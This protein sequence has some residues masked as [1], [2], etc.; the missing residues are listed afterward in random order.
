MRDDNEKI[1]EL[2]QYEDKTNILLAFQLCVGR[3]GRYS[4]EI[5]KELREHVFLCLDHGLETRHFYALA[6]LDLSYMELESMSGSIGKLKQLKILE[7]MCNELTDLPPQ[8]GQ[9]INLRRLDCSFN[10]L[11]TVPAEIGQLTNLKKLFLSDNQLTDLPEELRQLNNLQVL[12]ISD[13]PMSYEVRNKI[14]QWFPDCKVD[15]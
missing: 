8:I 5:A 10:D 3:R 7:A 9:L 11:K 13:N 15:T 4:R 2:L 1:L 6:N 12:D 14:I